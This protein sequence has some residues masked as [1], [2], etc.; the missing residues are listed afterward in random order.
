MSDS[1]IKLTLGGSAVSKYQSDQNPF[2]KMPKNVAAFA[3]RFN[4]G[5]NKFNFSSEY[6]YKINDPSAINNYIY[7]PGAAFIFSLF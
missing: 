6:A 3:G 4:L 1:K 7:K 2:Y 5:I